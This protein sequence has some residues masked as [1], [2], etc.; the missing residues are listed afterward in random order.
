[1]LLLLGMSVGAIFYATRVTNYQ[2]DAKMFF[3]ILLP[4]II[5]EAGNR[6]FISKAYPL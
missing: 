1:M 3:Y 5:L 2:M 4:P 6:H